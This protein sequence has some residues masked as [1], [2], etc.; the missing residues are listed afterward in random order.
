MLSKRWAGLLQ[1]PGPAWSDV[2]INTAAEF[3]LG[4]EVN[5]EAMMAWFCRRK[6]SIR[7]LEVAG[8]F[9]KLPGVLIE[10]IYLSQAASLRELRLD[11]LAA[12]VS[13]LDLPALAALNGLEALATRSS[14][15]AGRS[16]H[17]AAFIDTLS[18]LPALKDLESLGDSSRPDAALPTVHQLAALQRP[19]LTRLRLD[20]GS[21]PESALVLG[22]LPALASCGLAWG[23][24]RRALQVTPASFAGAPC[25]SRLLLVGVQL[26]L[27]PRCLSSLRMLEDVCLFNCGLTAVPAALA[28][29]APN[30]RQLDLR[31]NTELQID[32]AGFNTLVALP[33]LRMLNLSDASFWSVESTRFL[34]QFLVEWQAL[35]VGAPLPALQI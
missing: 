21:A 11:Y 19:S 31:G 33:K 24:Q 6:G 5:L 28:G 30:L 14:E 3:P 2:V 13:N 1:G 18:R 32:Q 16:D 9:Q 12:R 25:L 22:S 34:A 29:A 4:V 15:E 10:V 23:G 17:A 27:A 8:D 20:M 35:H 7:E 26:Q